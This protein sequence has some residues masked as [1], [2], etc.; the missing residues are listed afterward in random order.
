M[1]SVDGRNPDQTIA[2]AL[3]ARTPSFLD[4]GLNY[5][6]ITIEMMF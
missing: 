3:A 5:E 1:K 2:G 4:R 6:E